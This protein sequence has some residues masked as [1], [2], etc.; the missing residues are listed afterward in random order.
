MIII[1]KKTWLSLRFLLL[2]YLFFINQFSEGSD[3]ISPGQSLTGN[4]TL[5]SEG[6]IFELGFFTP[7]NSRNYYIGIWYRSLPDKPVIWVANRKQPVSNPSSS[8]FK[9]FGDGNVVLLNQSGAVIWST[10][11]TSKVQNSTTAKLLDNGNFVVRNT[12]ESSSVTWQSFDHPTDHWIP[13]NKLGYNKLTH[14]KQSLVS[15]RSP[16]NPAPSLF[17]VEVQE[18]GTSHLLL[19]NGS[20]V[21]WNSGEWTGKI[22]TLVPEI[23]SNP[24]V[25]NVTYVSNG[26]ESYFTYASAIPNAFTRFVLDATGQYKQFVW[27]KNFGEWRLLWTR[28][29]QQCE[30]YAFCGPFGICNQQRQPLCVCIHGF[31]PKMPK[32]WELGYH[33]DG[34]VRRVPLLCD[35]GVKDK[36][37]VMRNVH[38]PEKSESL[39]VTTIEECEQA[40]LSN[41]SCNA[42]AYDNGCSIWAGDLFN[43]EQLG[44]DDGTGKV[45]HLRIAASDW[46]G[47]TVKAK[48][49]TAWIVAAAVTGSFSLFAI[50]LVILRRRRSAGLFEAV[51]NTLVLFKYRDLKSATKNFSEKLGEGGFGSV[52]KGTL[53]NSTAIAVKELKSLKQGEKQFCAEVKTIGMI[54]HINLVRLRGICVDA[55]KRFLVYEYMPRGSLESVLFR[56]STSILDWESRY[57]IAIGTARGLAYLHEECRDCIIHCDI[58][59]E[60]ILLDEEYNPKVADFGLAKLIGR[61]FSRV[62]TTM[63]GTRGYLAPEWISG[64]AVTAKA[65]VF[66]YGMLLLEVISG[67]RNRELLEEGFD[68][69]FPLRVANTVYEGE[70]VHGLLDDRLEGNAMIE[71]LT[72]ACKV[73]CWCIQDDDKDRPTMGQV[74]KFLEGVSEVGIPP[75]ARFLQRLAEDP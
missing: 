20:D 10:N 44:T 3:T 23:Q 37:L 53:L 15:W 64:E 34:C 12:L 69:Y 65:D 39:A 50:V 46:V 57:K 14:E 33:T 73:A 35:D 48:R 9:L 25:T 63:R 41:C 30:V 74:V 5:T 8:V 71:E 24:Y 19:W 54:Q 49:K 26:N 62:L 22:F 38:F 68:D 60:N 43:L 27:Q 55:S 16:E 56:K 7:G 45:F 51:E 1:S 2:L 42:F 72:R 40:C 58:K 67:R 17:S 66:S 21:Y 61:D 36:F 13:G 32:S 28:P 29:T 52:F 70:S 31:E 4:Q 6:G 47:T 18:N 75:V 11:S 59:P